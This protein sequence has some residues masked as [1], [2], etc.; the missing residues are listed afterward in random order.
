MK[1][2]VIDL[3]ND[4]ANNKPVPSR[5]K[6]LDYIY[7]FDIDENTYTRYINNDLDNPRG[8]LEDID[9][10]NAYVW[11]N[12]EVEIIEEKPKKI[13]ELSFEFINSHGNIS[14]HK[15]SEIDIINKINELTKKVNYL[16][17]K[18]DKDE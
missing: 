10:H 1:I 9:L 15:A 14:Q 16:L 17:K 11:F 3:F 8:L 6:I 2:K 18:S 5:V 4:I 13:D 12:L 7:H